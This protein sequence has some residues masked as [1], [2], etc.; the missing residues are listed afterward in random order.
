MIKK[1]IICSFLFVMCLISLQ[2]TNA[3]DIAV[4]PGESIQNAVNMASDGDKIIVYDNNNNPFTYKESIIIN[5]EV[6][7]YANGNV[8]IE[9]QNNNSAVFT[10]NPSGAGSTI[11]NF[12]LSKSS[13]CVV[14]NNADNCNIIGNSIIEASLVGIQFYGNITNTMV[15]EN[16]ITGLNASYGNGISFESGSSTYNV[17]KGNTIRNFLNGILFNQKS[18]YIIVLSNA[19]E[20]YGSQGAGIYATDNSKMMQIINNTV[21]GYEDGIA[22]QQIGTNT[23]TKYKIIGNIVKANKNGLWVLLNYSTISSNTAAQNNVS[24]LDITG[25]NNYISNNYASENGVCGI[26]LGRYSSNDYC[27]IT[28]NTLTNNLGGINSASHHTT[29]SN[30]Y[31][32][33]NKDI[34]IVSTANNVTIIDN[35]II[36]SANC[37]IV[38]GTNNSVQDC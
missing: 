25:I 13:Y 22:V 17:I 9:A 37:I 15:T 11:Q 38:S 7:I 6:H 12:R 33:D 20:G 21:T 5:K 32:Y 18:E 31:L 16:N 19:V 26:A 4:H 14:I 30:N 28:N 23:A 36:N 3:A 35:T 29:I 24:G 8:T 2:S 10:V 34:G 1:M 27:F